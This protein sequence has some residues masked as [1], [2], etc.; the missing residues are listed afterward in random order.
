MRFYLEYINHLGRLQKKSAHRRLQAGFTITEVL[1]AGLM[2]LIAV[3]VAGIGLINLLR[4]NYRANADSEIRNNLNRT[5]EFVSDE[6][7]RARIIA[8]SETAITST[9]VPTVAK[10]GKAVL[11]FQIPDPNNPSQA[12]LNEQIV[13]YT[14]GPESSLTGSRVLWRFGPNLDD[15]GNYITPADVATWQHSPVTDMLAATAKDS[16]C[17]TDFNLIVAPSSTVDGFFAC[18][19]RDGNQVILNANAQVKMT[20]NEKVE[21]SVSTRVFSR[22]CG[23]IF[24]LAS[25]TPPPFKKTP[26][27]GST[28]PTLPIVTVPATVKAE[29]ITEG[30]CTFSSS[31]GVVTAPNKDLPGKPEGALGSPVDANAGDGIVVSVNGLRN[32]YEDTET[33]T[34]DVYTSDSSNLPTNIKSLTNNQILFV[35]TT[36]TTPP[37]S[38]QILVTIV[39]K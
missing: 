27:S 15:K 20:T 16:N 8:N 33:Q 34:V 37:T 14:T 3:L 18:V 10:A 23:E 12:P 25:G 19:H 26:G 24:C 35:F 7:R 6:V 30:T 11:A 31:C 4:S 13:Y 22:A 5:L 17:P 2:M 39:P 32:V 29:V 36:K 1:L 21:Y 38:Y 9:E 28:T